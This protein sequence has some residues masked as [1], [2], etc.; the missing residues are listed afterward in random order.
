MPKK[1]RPRQKLKQSRVK[2]KIFRR[3]HVKSKPVKKKVTVRKQRKPDRRLKPFRSK[4]LS[5]LPVEFQPKWYRYKQPL[6]KKQRQKVQ[7]ELA[8]LRQKVIVAEVRKEDIK[9]RK[10]GVKQSKRLTKSPGKIRIKYYTRTG[11]LA[12]T[13]DLNHAFEVRFFKGKEQYGAKIGPHDTFWKGFK[14]R[15]FIR[16]IAVSENIEQIFGQKKEFMSGFTWHGSFEWFPKKSRLDAVLARKISTM[17]K[18]HKKLVNL[19]VSVK[20]DMTQTTMAEVEIKYPWSRADVRRAVYRQLLFKIL[21]NI[22]AVGGNTSDDRFKKRPKG[23]TVSGGHPGVNF[24]ALGFPLPKNSVCPRSCKIAGKCPFKKGT[25]KPLSKCSGFSYYT[26]GVYARGQDDY[27]AKYGTDMR[28]RKV[29]INPRKEAI[30]H[31]K[32]NSI[33]NKKRH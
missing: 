14:F 33:R 7:R 13:Q 12:A 1:R 19:V 2:K 10:A 3:Q 21:Q 4:L 28:G 20:S 11:T 25:G 29:Q 23:K 16:S 6:T 17:L 31:A 8:G 24:S 5:R 27:D 30:S 22:R 9:L 26:I 15:D 32:A 18:G